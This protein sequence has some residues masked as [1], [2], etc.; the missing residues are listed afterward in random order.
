MIPEKVKIVAKQIKEMKIIGATNTASFAVKSL[1]SVRDTRDLP[2]CIALLSKSRPTEPMMRNGLKYVQYRVDEGAAISEAVDGFLEMVIEGRKTIIETGS[3]RI[4]DRMKIITH[5]HSG[6][7]ID[8][9][10]RAHDNG[11]KFSV[12]CTETR[13]FY[14]GRITAAELADY[15]IPVTQIVDSAFRDV[16]NDMDLVLI[17]ADAITAEGNILNKI[18]SALFAL[19]ADEARTTF[20]CATNLLKFDP[21]TKKGFYEPIEMRTAKQVWPEKPANVNVFNPIFEEVP[22]E[23]IDYLITE[24]GIVSPYNVLNATRAKYKW[25]FK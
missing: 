21:L 11:K 25:M 13:P 14:Q 6:K 15:G 20:A 2:A 12:Y 3:R 17:G 9:L 19:A 10:K 5:C 7:V 23:Y 22:A 1:K 24:D 8:I 4:N 16:I 18:G